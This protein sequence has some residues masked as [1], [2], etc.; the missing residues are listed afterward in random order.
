MTLA[1]EQ[2]ARMVAGRL[3]DKP[4]PAERRTVGTGVRPEY[5]DRYSEIA[6]DLARV[7]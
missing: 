4:T 5:H 2:A 6:E 7:N 3:P 1:D